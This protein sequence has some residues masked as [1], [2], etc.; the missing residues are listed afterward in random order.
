MSDKML[1]YIMVVENDKLFKWIERESKIYT[2][3]EIDFE[4]RVNENFE[5]MI[6][7]KAEEDFNYKQPLPYWVVVDKENRIFVYKRGWSGSNNWEYRLNNKISFWVWGHIDK[8]DF[9]EDILRN[10]LKREIEEEINIK[11]K[12]IESIEIIWYINI[13]NWEV[14]EVHLWLAYLVKVNNTNFELLDWEL[15]NWEFVNIHALEK[16]VYSNDYDT[17]AW[18]RILF[19]PIKKI[20]S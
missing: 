3:D 1:K 12:D 5:Y 6:R 15:D 7:W 13:D 11:Q 4:K 10:T 19:E 18:L 8:W 9:E 20:L 17:E 16:M 14:E 2:N